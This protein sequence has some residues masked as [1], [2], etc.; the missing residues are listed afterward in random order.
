MRFKV[1][2][3]G[4]GL[5]GLLS[6]CAGGVNIE[7]YTDPHKYIDLAV[8][9]ERERIY[10]M[11]KKTV[12]MTLAHKTDFRVSETL[13][14]GST[15]DDRYSKKGA[16]FVLG[17]RYVISLHVSKPYQEDPEYIKS[18]N[19]AGYKINSQTT[20]IDGV[21]I[22]LLEK[23]EGADFAIFHLP[24]ELCRRYCNNGVELSTNFKPGERIFWLENP[25]AYGKELRYGRI[26]SLPE[27]IEVKGK[28]WRAFRVDLPFEN[29]SSGS[30]V[31]TMYGQLIG[32]AIARKNGQGIVMPVSGFMRYL[33]VSQ[34]GNRLI[35]ERISDEGLAKLKSGPLEE[36]VRTI[37][38]TTR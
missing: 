29:G 18:R 8:H 1:G 13:K 34:E 17:N 22:T 23:D 24:E 15:R 35:A 25:E 4:L 32:F 9:R 3:L 16:G 7:L 12:N 21:A 36:K 6:G 14:D 11:F 20:S 31:F 37:T 2:L 28:T 5:T 27:R 30:P 26:A 38:P 19:V 10:E 33:N